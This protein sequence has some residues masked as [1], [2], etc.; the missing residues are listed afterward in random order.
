M[1]FLIFCLMIGFV[2]A[3]PGYPEEVVVECTPPDGYPS[4]WSY[5]IW[6]SGVWAQKDNVTKC[7][8][9]NLCYDDPPG[10]FVKVKLCS[11]SK[12]RGLTQSSNFCDVFLKRSPYLLLPK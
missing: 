2:I 3:A 1:D 11:S 5:S 4:T 7:I 12:P 6:M 10:N 8:D 9:P